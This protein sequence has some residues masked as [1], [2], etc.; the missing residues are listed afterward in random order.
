MEVY[1]W[2]RHLSDGE[3]MMKRLVNSYPRLSN[4]WA[5]H[6]DLPGDT[7]HFHVW[8]KQEHPYANHGAEIFSYIE[9]PFSCPSYVGKYSST[10]EHLGHVSS[11]HPEMHCISFGPSGLF[12]LPICFMYGVFA[13]IIGTATENLLT[14][15]YSCI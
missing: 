1:S 15:I 12:L 3:W 8:A 7:P 5:M 14:H 9:P 6:N 11:N 4:H 10:K 13:Y 2:E